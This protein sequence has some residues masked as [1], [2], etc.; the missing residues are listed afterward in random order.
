V[1]KLLFAT[2]TVTFL[3]GPLAFGSEDFKLQTVKIL[4]GNETY[5]EPGSIYQISKE[6]L[7]NKK[8][9]NVHE[10]LKDIPGVSIQ[11]EDG[12][13]LRPNIGLRGTHPHRSK[14]I[15]LLE[16]GVLLGPAP[17]SAPAAYYFPLFSKITGVE[18][19]KGPS[20]V[21]YGPNS[22]GGAINF[23][24]RDYRE[25]S[26]SEID[27]SFGS[28][29]TQKLGAWHSGS[30]KSFKWLAEYNRANSE[31]FKE[32]PRGGNTGF[33]KNDILLKG[34]YTFNSEKERSLDFKYSWADEVSNETYMG[35]T[36]DDFN[37]N[38]YSRYES[39]STDRLEWEHKQYQVKYFNEWSENIFSDLTVYRNEFTRT[40]DKLNGFADTGIDLRDVFLSPT[41]QN[42]DFLAV[43]KGQKDSSPSE[44]LRFGINDRDYV[45]QGISL[46]TRFITHKSGAVKNHIDLGLLAH[47]DEIERSHLLQ[48]ADMIGGRLVKEN[49]FVDTDNSNIDS[50]NA[51]RLFL[52]DTYESNKWLLRIGGRFERVENKRFNKSTNLTEVTNTENFFVPGAGVSYKLNSK[53]LVF[54]GANRGY[55][56]PGPGQDAT[57]EPEEAI[58]YELGYRYRGDYFFEL[59][60]FYSDYKNL[61]GTCSFSTGCNSGELDVQFNGGEAKI[62][63]AE[64]LA[65][66]EMTYKEFS[67]P[68]KLSATYTNATFNSNILSTNREWGGSGANP[69]QIVVGDPLPYIPELMASVNLG[70]RYKKITSNLFYNYKSNIFDQAAAAGQVEIPSFST[71]NLNTRYQVDKDLGVYLNVE[72]LLGNDYV[73][74]LRP[75]GFRPGAPRWVS[76][77]ATY[78]F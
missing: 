13:G 65:G 14:K 52:I 2:L 70:L 47:N 39:T 61:L 11:Q 21:K 24:T 67:F 46:E 73:S 35:L 69:A 19:Y 27:Y 20:S 1:T 74:S 43:L 48:D 55:T 63:G 38:P 50:T 62:F 30:S 58:N 9:T 28:F 68:V 59:I 36:S 26:T 29:N 18:V 41:G 34:R 7:K 17:Y 8:T 44:K 64:F 40:W 31:G 37:R 66:T 10:V 33:E 49:A 3:S 23:L 51:L 45:S 42:E 71:V 77:G 16:D 72:N 53:N 32:L 15:T 57:V 56:L 76:L 25:K 22:I 6:E 78:T 54:V 60:G 75:F 5:V 12:L 4:G